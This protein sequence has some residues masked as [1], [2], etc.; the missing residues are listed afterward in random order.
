MDQTVDEANYVFNFFEDR[1]QVKPQSFIPKKHLHEEYVRWMQESGY[2]PLGKSKF[3][4]ALLDYYKDAIYE[5]RIRK[6]QD[7]LIWRGIKMK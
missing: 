4:A 7:I 2:K 5:D 6:P 1:L 3:N